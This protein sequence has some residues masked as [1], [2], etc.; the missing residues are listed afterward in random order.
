MRPA[1]AGLLTL[2]L[3][4]AAVACTACTPSSPAAAP[5]PTQV[6]TALAGHARALLAGDARAFL[7]GVDPA[8]AADGFRRRQQQQLQNIAG[9]PLRSWSYLLDAAVHDAAATRAATR[10]Y[11]EPALIVHLSVQYRFEGIGQPYRHELWWTF[12]RA[13]GGARIAGDDDLAGA[14][15]ASWRGPW[16]FGPVVAARGTASLVLGHVSDATAL[17]GLA[18]TADE[19]ILAVDAVWGTDWARQVVV[20]AP[21]SAAEF[22]ALTGGPLTG[23]ALP[24]DSAV[25]VTAGI[26]PAT[27]RAYGQR[28][29]LAPGA[30]GQLSRVGEQIVLRHELTHLATAS[31]TAPGTP[32]WLVEGFAEFV[33]QRGSGQPVSDA[34]G[35]LRADVRHG[36]VPTVLP[37]DS[38]FAAGAPARPQAYQQAW[39]ACRLIAARAGVAGLVRLYRAVGTAAAEPQQALAAALRAVLHES[40]AAFTAQWR[41]YLRAQLSG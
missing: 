25:A 20:Q 7:A 33:G 11:G 32:R 5:T 16:D 35:E 30:L 12:V 4:V 23:G 19:A 9:V 13:A 6:R 41:A 27:S 15:G 39:L 36:K 37:P 24:E 31:D 17:P 38:A 14:G 29:V 10:R 40:S 1:L 22:G 8:R 21:T 34:A 18:V 28:V 3:A 2:V 26:D